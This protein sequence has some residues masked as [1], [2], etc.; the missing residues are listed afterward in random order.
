MNKMKK[1]LDTALMRM[2]LIWAN[3]GNIMECALLPL[4]FLKPS[5]KIGVMK[6]INK[7]KITT[8]ALRAYMV[9][10]ITADMILLG[11]IIWLILN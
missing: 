6:M 3:N 2:I 7:T 11:G 1:E 9:Y 4:T 10:S 8:W 5:C